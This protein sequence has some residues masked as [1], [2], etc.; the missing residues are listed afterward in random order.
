VSLRLREL[1]K[2]FERHVS[3]DAEGVRRDAWFL[4]NCLAAAAGRDQVRLEAHTS[5]AKNRGGMTGLL[6]GPLE[7]TDGRAQS[8]EGTVRARW[9]HSLHLLLLRR[10]LLA[11]RSA[12]SVMPFALK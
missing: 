12:K 5:R 11:G 6:N 1:R 8:F 4:L 3:F 10:G 7:A 9:H 2:R